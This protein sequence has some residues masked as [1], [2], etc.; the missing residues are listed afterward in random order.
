MK[1][2]ISWVAFNNDFI[3]GSGNVD[4]D[5][6]P[7]YLFHKYFFQDYDKHIILSAAKED[8]IRINFL[9]AAIRNDFK[10]H[11]IEECYLN[12]SDVIDLDEIKTKIESKLLEFSNEEIDIFFSPGTSIMQVTW[13][14]LHTSLG[15]RTRLLQTRPAIKSKSGQVELIEIKSEQSSIP[16]TA[17]LKEKN[18]SAKERTYELMDDFLLTASIKSVYERAFKI[19]QTDNVTTLITGESGTGKEHL[20]RFIHANSIRKKQNFIAVNCSS[21]ND[22]LLESRLFGYLKGSFTGA[23]DDKKGIFE[24][25]DGGTIFLDEFGDISPY[26]QQSLLR[27]L[28]EKEITPIGGKSKKINVRIIAATNKN[29]TQICKKGEF[30]WDLFYR[31]AIAELELP[32]LRNRGKQEINEL[33]NFFLKMKKKELKKHK[34]LKINKEALQHILAYPFPGNIRELENFIE[35]LYVFCEDI[36]SP[37]DL[38]ERFLQVDENTSLR[39][40][41]VEKMHIMKVLK[42]YDGNQRQTCLALGYKS[43]NTLKSKLN[44]YRIDSNFDHSIE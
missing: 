34:V 26:M 33:L 3:K 17:I 21:L 35:S 40:Q 39:W 24:Q 32:A 16:V 41:D 43:I 37:K 1:I 19:A 27:V 38:A 29:L 31:L 9:V 4:K 13:Y 7:N 25:A 22:S 18:I 15:L 5:N 14:I 23:T 10:N 36:V 12:I 20:S 11:N 42:L 6:S 44:Q 30:R 8:D 2:L 28:Q